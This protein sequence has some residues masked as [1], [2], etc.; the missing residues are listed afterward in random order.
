[1]QAAAPVFV[2]SSSSL[3]FRSSQSSTDQER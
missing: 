2:P 3:S 1:L